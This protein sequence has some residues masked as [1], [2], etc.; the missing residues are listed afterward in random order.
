[1]GMNSLFQLFTMNRGHEYIILYFTARKE[2]VIIGTVKDVFR[3]P[4]GAPYT[5]NPPY[6]YEELGKKILKMVEQVQTLTAQD[7]PKYPEP[8]QAAT[9]IKSWSKFCRD[10]SM[11]GIKWS[12]TEQC[13]E[14][15]YWKRISSAGYTSADNIIQPKILSFES[16]PEKIGSVV[17]E[18]MEEALLKA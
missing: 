10:R 11:I 1:M 16:S 6:T 17:E 8:Y 14:F 4:C 3:K 13:I 2:I 5:L 9:G 15:S 18:M 12:Y 7:I